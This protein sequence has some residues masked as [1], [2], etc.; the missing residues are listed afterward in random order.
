MAPRIELDFKNVAS[1]RPHPG[2][3]PWSR[4]RA[5]KMVSWRMALR[6]RKVLSGAA[7][8]FG[9]AES[10]ALLFV[11]SAGGFSGNDEAI[12]SLLFTFLIGLIGGLDGALIQDHRF[13][14]D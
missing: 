7:M 13:P 11:G 12:G 14:P 1:L 10:L 8:G 4:Q 9:I 3:R 6:T 5:F 2:G